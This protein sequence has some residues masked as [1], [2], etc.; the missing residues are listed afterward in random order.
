M[1]IDNVEQYLRANYDRHILLTYRTVKKFYL[2]VE[3]VRLDIC[4]LKSCR[5]KDI[6]PKFL[7]FKTANRNLGSSTT[8]KECQRRLLKAEIDHK[9]QHLNKLKKMYRSSIT[10]LQQSYSEDL[11]ER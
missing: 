10:V 9:Y 6:I 11:F 4:F 5:T 7:W 3:L 2:R 1:N 8:Y